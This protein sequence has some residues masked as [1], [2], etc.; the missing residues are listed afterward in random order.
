MA[1]RRPDLEAIEVNP[2]F[3][4]LSSVI[5]PMFPL[6][7][8]E[9]RVYFYDL[10]ADVA[11]ETGRTL[12]V[13]PTSGNVL[14]A[15]TTF[16][17]LERIARRDIPDDEVRLMG[18][19][20]QAENR[21]ARITKRS[22]QRSLEVDTVAATVGDGTLSG[23]DILGSIISAIDTGLDSIHRIPGRTALVA[24]WTTIRRISRFQEILDR[25]VFTGVLTEQERSVRNVSEN[26]L[27]DALGVDLVL[28]GDDAQWAG[29]NVEVA[30]LIRLPDAA[31]D[32]LDDPQIGRTYT[33][34]P[35][36]AGG[37]GVEITSFEDDDTLSFKIT[38]RM[39]D[40]QIVH[41]PEG[42]YR[43]TGIDDANAVT[44]TTT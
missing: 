42:L 5:F 23:Q 32:P 26:I 24:S 14:S 43:L 7:Q 25:M 16:A 18:G 11:A 27:A 22:I 38:G 17:A 41:N 28:A 35:E 1:T 40:D 39:W 36:D 20:P 6:G 8:K 44:T 30:C 15:N 34:I 4:Y 37:D 9:G 12:G 33:Y 19:L 21:A 13:A 2:P 29:A 31:T 10:D 3:G